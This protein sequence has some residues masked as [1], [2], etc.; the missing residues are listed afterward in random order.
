MVFYLNVNNIE[1]KFNK[2]KRALFYTGNENVK[3]N[4]ASKEKAIIDS[5]YFASLRGNNLNY[6]EW[7]L[8]EVDID[9]L[10]KNYINNRFKTF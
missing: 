5:I 8:S 7:D 1:Y 4:I 9:E 10:K 3:F 6:D 2:I